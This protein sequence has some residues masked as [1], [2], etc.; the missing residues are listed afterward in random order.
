M[1][2]TELVAFLRSMLADDAEVASYRAAPAAYLERHGL[3]AVPRAEIA[4]ALPEAIAG[5]D[6][7]RLRHVR[8]YLGVAGPKATLADAIAEVLP[9]DDPPQGSSAG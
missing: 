2:R 8:P 7:D 6:A 1:E 9:A 3:G 5:L 4:G